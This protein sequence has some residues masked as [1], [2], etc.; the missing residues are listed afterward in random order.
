MFGLL[1]TTNLLLFVCAAAGAAVLELNRRKIADSDGA[2]VAAIK[3]GAVQLAGGLALFGL[4]NLIF[5]VPLMLHHRKPASS[6][7]QS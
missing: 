4:G 6:E 2:Q 1:V 5:S 7:P 3:L